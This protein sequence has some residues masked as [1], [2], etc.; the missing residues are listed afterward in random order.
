MSETIRLDD[1]LVGK[2]QPAYIIAEMSANH[3]GSKE[4]ALEIIR[5]AKDAGADCVKVQ[6]YTPETMTLDSDKKWFKIDK[7]TWEGENLYSL[8]QKAYTPWEWQEDLKKEA[9]KIGIDFFSTP[10]ENTAVDFLE[11]LGVEFYKVASFS[12][13]NLPFLKYLAQKDKPIIMSTGMATLAEIDEAVRTIREVGNEQLALLNCSS[14]YPSIADDM[15]LKNIKNLEETFGVP[16]GLS[17]H[18][19]GSVAAVTSVAMGAKIIEK[20]FC[21]SR[22]IENPDSSFSMEPDEFKKMVNDIR[23]AERAIGKID[24]SISEKEKNS[25]IFRRSI[26]AVED[27]KAGEEITEENIKIIRPGFGLK[28]KHWDN[29]LKT[30]AIKDIEKG[31][32]LSWSMIK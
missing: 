28:P 32:P 4:R 19:L 29:V 15:N 12:I 11:D 13:T 1:K 16:V 24:Y 27:I 6:T 17:D 26:F 22:E 10:Y 5:A 14:A 31:T 7:G 3:A 23:A 25:R 21:M 18:S 8:Y 2:D 9:E 30:K 20:H